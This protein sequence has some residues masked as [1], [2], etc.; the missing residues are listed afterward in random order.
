MFLQQQT[1]FCLFLS[2][3]IYARF[4][5]NELISR[6]KSKWDP[7]HVKK[8]KGKLVQE[9][10][11]MPVGCPNYDLSTWSDVNLPG[12]LTAA[13]SYSN[14]EAYKNPNIEL[15]SD[16]AYHPTEVLFPLIDV[17]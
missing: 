2:H 3:R 14:P 1:Y 4:P 11:T 5:N 17:Y 13:I 12:S 9:I 16:C 8:E 15:R 10:S 6:S 7:T